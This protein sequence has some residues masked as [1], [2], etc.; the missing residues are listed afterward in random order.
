MP[1]TTLPRDVHRAL[2]L[3]NENPQAGHE[4]SALA[5]ACQV[6]PR[7][8]QRHFREFLG[9]SPTEV[10]RGIRLD[11]IRRTLLLG[12][13]DATVSGLATQWGFTHFGRFSGMYRNRFGETPS[14]TLRRARKPIRR[15]WEVAVPAVTTLDRPTIA[16]LP[17]RSAGPAGSAGILSEEIAIALSRRR[18]LTVTSAHRAEYLLC[19]QAYAREGDGVRVVVTLRETA[20]DRLL[21]ADASTGPFEGTIGFEER[22]AE[23][24]TMKLLAT[25]HHV[26]LDRAS[27]KEISDLTARELTARAVSHA[28]VEEPV[29]FSKALEFALKATER[30]PLD[31]RP[32]AL[33]AYCHILAVSSLKRRVAEYEPARARAAEAARLHARDPIA[34]AIL[35]GAHILM[36]DLDAA[37]IHVERALALDGGCAWAWHHAGRS[38]IFRGFPDAGTELLRISE[39]LDMSGML[40]VLRM[41]SFGI[42]QFEA[43][44]Y[45]EAARC[46]KRALAE[47]PEAAWLNRLLAPAFALVG[48]KDEARAHHRAMLDA[49]PLFVFNLTNQSHPFSQ[50]FIDQMANGWESIGVRSVQ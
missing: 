38:L 30:A 36:H 42:A 3:L 37:D 40:R 26:E 29:S 48:C 41:V 27:R 32:M 15:P 20:T 11:R 13:D 12:R 39:S 45:L 23:R 31:P 10:L 43:G 16:V 28:L 46:W 24:V 14:A 44:Q 1:T 7:T 19:G 35:A 22:V 5:R 8:L 6:T 50:A 33:S 18:D 25:I 9:H 17:F 49:Y 4:V 34:E 47:S 21:W 2:Q